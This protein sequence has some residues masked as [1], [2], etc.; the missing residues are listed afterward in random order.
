MV[1]ARVPRPGDVYWIDPNPVAGRE[2]KDRHP[3]VVIMPQQINALGVSM[4]VPVTTGAETA[5]N[6][7]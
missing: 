2:M 6:R 4:T 5:R 7:A 3:F 1:R